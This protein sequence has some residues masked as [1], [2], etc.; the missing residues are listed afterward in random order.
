MVAAGRE[1][2]KR[3]MIIINAIM[4]LRMKKRHRLNLCPGWNGYFGV[5]SVRAVFNDASRFLNAF[6]SVITGVLFLFD[7]NL[8]KSLA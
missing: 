3:S 1:T 8:K 5:S 4:C 2:T 6:L 7:I